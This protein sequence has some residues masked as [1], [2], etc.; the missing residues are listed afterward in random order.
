MRIERKFIEFTVHYDIYRNAS[1][2][3]N[4]LRDF[5]GIQVH[6]MLKRLIYSTASV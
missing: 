2:Q 3:S 4:A 1:H 5:H 6:A